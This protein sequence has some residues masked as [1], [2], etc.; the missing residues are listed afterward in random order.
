ME[1]TE[2]LELGVRIHMYVCDG[3]RQEDQDAHV[4]RCKEAPVVTRTA[5]TLTLTAGLCILRRG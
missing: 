4:G 1:R 3:Q 5:H 2:M